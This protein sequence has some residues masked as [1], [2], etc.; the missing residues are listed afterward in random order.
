MSWLKNKEFG[1]IK[2]NGKSLE[3]YNTR[4]T[5]NSIHVGY[6][7]KEARWNGDQILVYLADGRVRVYKDLTNY[8]TM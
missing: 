3:V 7:I 1:V 4:T 6:D 5:Y 8:S 2:V